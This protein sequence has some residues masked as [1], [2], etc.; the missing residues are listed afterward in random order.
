MTYFV[1]CRLV[2]FVV[3]VDHRVKIKENEKTS[4]YLDPARELRKLRKMRVSVIPIVNG[5]LE[6]VGKV[7]N[8]K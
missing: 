1:A 2:E 8:G 4:N 3:Q 6:T 5:A 7:I